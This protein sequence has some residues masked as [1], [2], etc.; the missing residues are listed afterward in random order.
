MSLIEI[1]FWICVIVVLY[2]HIGYGVILFVLV[3]LRAGDE[4]SQACLTE[5]ALPPV[6]VLVAAYNEE[7]CI[8][9]KILNT[10]A[11]QYPPGK[12]A[13]IIV[14]DGSDDKT[15]DIIGRF[16]QILHL[17]QPVR[18]GKTA[19]ITRAM[20]YVNTPIVVFTDANAMVNKIAL[21]KMVRH[22][23]H[24]NTGAVA[25][26]KRILKN[27]ESDAAEA[28]EGAYWKYESA[29]KAWDASLNTVVG[30]AGEL[31]SI[32]TALY[33]APPDDTIIEDFYMSL[34]IAQQG[35]K[36]A[37][38]PDAF[39]EEE[40]SFSVQEEMKRKIRIA[41]GGIQAIIRLRSLFNIFKYGFLSFQFIS[42]RVLRWTLAPVALVSCFVL[43]S[44]IVAAP[45]NYIYH[46]LLLCQFV[47][48][49]SS[50]VGYI[51]QKRKIK[52]ALFFVPYYFL[53]INYAILAGMFRYFRG[54][55]G[56]IWDKA[57]RSFHL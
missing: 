26:E 2:T 43:N 35:Y 37:Y 30:A 32:R 21:T 10:L 33:Q 17:H 5:E 36:V 41:A 45:S 25:G 55:Q 31:F 54:S 11:L 44:I 7:G 18:Q 19:A 4:V 48:Y 56:V 49:I 22:Y 29:L 14:S 51:F 47:F 8:E 9:Q 1:F 24:E 42:H 12:L 57:I 23:N 34:A 28:G 50:L 52:Y 40:A 13:I 27:H 15:V 16:P 20:S 46:L 3:K 39:A 6:T 38:E 53:F